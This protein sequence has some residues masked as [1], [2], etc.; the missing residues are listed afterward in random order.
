MAAACGR[1]GSGVL[2]GASVGMS[3]VS[4]ASGAATIVISGDRRRSGLQTVD[5]Q[6][7]NLVS[8][9]EATYDGV[10]RDPAR[11][12]V[13]IPMLIARAR[14]SGNTEALII[15]LR[16]QAWARHVVL[17]N[18][19]AK[20]ILDQ[21]ARLAHREGL[22]QRLGDVLVTRAVALHELG[23]RTE[24]RR[25]LARAESLVL[26]ERRPEINLQ[27]A[28]LE[29]NGGRVMAAATL[30]HRVLADPLSPADVWIKAANN[31]S[32]AYTELGKP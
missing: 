14:A 18:P 7:G 5:A 3:E 16:A 32:V 2:A 24:A 13:R 30:Y 22:D 1:P 31:L 11:Y 26:D 4:S 20:K 28:L 27:R 19:A 23:R 10:I 12:A 21:A 9:A 6:S 29:H 8:E 17:D 15:A 25:D